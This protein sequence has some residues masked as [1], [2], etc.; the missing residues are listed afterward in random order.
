MHLSSLVRVGANIHPINLLVVD[1]A[2]ERHDGHV[3]VA[4]IG[5]ELC[6]KRLHI[7]DRRVGL[8]AENPDYDP[9]EVLPHMDFEIWGR[10]MHSVQSFC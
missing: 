2:T 1:R 10:V 7:V 9:I 6:I 3:M 4:R 5:D 8:A